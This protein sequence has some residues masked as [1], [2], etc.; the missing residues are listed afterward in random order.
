MS[1]VDNHEQTSAPYDVGAAEQCFVAAGVHGIAGPI[2]AS[3]N[4]KSNVIRTLGWQKGGIGLVSTQAGQI[5]IQRYLDQAGTILVGAAITQ[6][7]TANTA[8]SATWSDGLPCG[9]VQITVTNSSGSTAATLSS[10]TVL[11]QSA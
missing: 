5:S 9:S 2:A 8:A 11:L 3:G 6:A 7:L 10:I 4:V 1:V